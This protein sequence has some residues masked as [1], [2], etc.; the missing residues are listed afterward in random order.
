ME[1]VLE[2]DARPQ[3]PRRPLGCL[4]EFCKQLTGEAREVVPT[5]PGQP[6]RQ[7]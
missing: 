7:N 1:D 2:V 5:P 4:D 3:D 6:E